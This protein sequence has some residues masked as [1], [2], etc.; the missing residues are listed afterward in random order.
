MKD[1]PFTNKAKIEV[2]ARCPVSGCHKTYKREGDL[3]NHIGNVH[4]DQVPDPEVSRSMAHLAH[5]G[6][7]LRALRHRAED[8]GHAP[9]PLEENNVEFD[10][11][12]MFLGDSGR[13]NLEE[14]EIEEEEEVER[15]EK[16]KEKDKEKRL[17]W[18]SPH[19]GRVKGRT[20]PPAYP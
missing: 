4:R 16:E 10:I 20:H 7:F 13:L 5:N 14:G 8:H 15:K 3:A 1:L 19:S 18:T 2:R 12:G 11:G 6:A 9:P 17:F